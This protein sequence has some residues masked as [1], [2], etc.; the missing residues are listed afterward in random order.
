MDLGLSENNI[1]MT[2]TDM[3]AEDFANP[4]RLISSD[5]IKYF[6][7]NEYV[8]NYS[9]HDEK[10]KNNNNDDEYP[11][12]DDDPN[13]YINEDTN[14][15]HGKSNHHTKSDDNS[16]NTHHNS[17]VS[18]EMQEMQGKSSDVDPDNEANWSH[19]ELILRK[20]D[21]MRKLG[22]LQES[23]T[24]L[25]QNY[26]LSSS[27]KAMKMEYELHSSIRGKRNALNWMSN[28]MIGIIKGVEMLNDNV[29]PFDMKF[30]NMWSNEVK[31]DISNYYDVLGEIYEKYTTPGKKMAPELKLF[32]MLTG[33]AVSIQMHRGIASYM[34]NNSNV[35][36]DLEDDPDK[37]SALRKKTEMKK[38][39]QKKKIDE[40][41]ANE[42]QMMRDRINTLDKLKKQQEDYNEIKHNS[43]Y[44]QSSFKDALVLSE[45]ATAKSNGSRKKEKIAK[46]MVQQ[47]AQQQQQQNR[48]NEL[49]REMKNL[50]NINDL[51]SKKKNNER[52]I[53]AKVIETVSSV[54]ESSVSESSKSYQKKN[55]HTESC[56]ESVASSSSIVRPL[57]LGKLIGKNFKKGDASSEAPSV[58]PI[59]IVSKATAEKNYIEGNISVGNSKDASNKSK[60]RGRP[61]KV[62]V[63]KH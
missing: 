20:I 6:N 21:M 13:N 15:H 57:E 24:R 12:M 40:K 63:S 59:E 33:S 49:T 10:N 18:E 48:K 53:M 26:N 55:R 25:T 45:S 56:S 7:K 43:K 23:G 5:E 29:N 17:S 46:Q 31:S 37:I 4:D 32:L 51:I 50:A 28:M 11:M 36:G 44:M 16:Y 8:Q 3:K 54:S 61:K 39:E 19:D 34:A 9:H 41:F 38:E 47:M 62:S 42:H 30:D 58:T 22:E 27:Y 14:T 1:S 35:S 2:T 60:G 52:K